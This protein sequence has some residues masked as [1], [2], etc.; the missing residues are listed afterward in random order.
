MGAA[1]IGIM[2][3]CAIV[4]AAGA[5]T[6]LGRPK[7]TLILNGETLLDR[8]VRTAQEAGYSDVIVVLG[9]FSNEIATTCQLRG[10]RTVVNADWPQGIGSSLRAGIAA[11]HPKTGVILM[12]CDMPFT[13]SAHLASLAADGQ[14]SATKYINGFGVPAFFP[15]T[16]VSKLAQI[17]P[18]VG[19]KDLLTSA[20]LVA[21]D[22]GEFDVDTPED[23]LRLNMDFSNT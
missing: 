7:Q 12:T 2:K 15:A 6:R 21:L 9:A 14:L 17:P 22:G 18:G 10:C 3:S 20:R 13:T 8:A 5:S 4:L 19:A 23:V 11:I 1:K 16:Q